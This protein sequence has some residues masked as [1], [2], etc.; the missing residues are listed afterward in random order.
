MDLKK[1]VEAI[2]GTG[3]VAAANSRNDEVVIGGLRGKSKAGAIIM[4]QKIIAD[5][6][7][8]RKILE[9]RVGNA[10]DVVVIKFDSMETARQFI[11]DHKSVKHSDGLWCNAS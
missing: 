1:Q 9:D 7:G 3:N 6:A 11:L 2:Q 5:V 8:H 10:P 4:C